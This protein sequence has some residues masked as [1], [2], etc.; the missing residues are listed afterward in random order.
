MS[1]LIRIMG[2]EDHENVDM[3]TDSSLIN[4][5]VGDKDRLARFASS[6]HTATSGRTVCR[7]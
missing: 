5:I 7:L 1:A 2:M 3:T 6:H 4:L